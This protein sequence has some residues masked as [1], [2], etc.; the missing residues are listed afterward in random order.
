MVA[1]HRLR[2]GVWTVAII[3][4]AAAII[5]LMADSTTG[6]VV[7][8]SDNDVWSYGASNEGK[9]KGFVDPDVG[10]EASGGGI[11]WAWVAIDGDG[12]GEAYTWPVETMS[13]WPGLRMPSL[14]GENDVR[15]PRYCEVP[16]GSDGEE[17][18]WEAYICSISSRASPR[19]VWRLLNTAKVI[20]VTVEGTRGWMLDKRLCDK[21]VRDFEK[22]ARVVDS[23]P[24]SPPSA[25][26]PL[27]QCQTQ[28][29]CLLST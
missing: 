25:K 17:Y 15:W 24:N 27:C 18:P 21:T 11:G 29:S 23:Q 8:A 9:S 22:L 4:P 1:S 13:L 28:S 16:G 12:G 10:T 20:G 26:M 19:M 6:C 7:N 14:S 3:W 5:R 2:K